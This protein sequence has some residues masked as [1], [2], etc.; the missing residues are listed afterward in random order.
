MTV[1]VVVNGQ[2]LSW[3]GRAPKIAAD[4]VEFVK[5]QFLLSEDWDGYTVTAQFT[6][7]GATYNQLLNN[8]CCALPTEIEAGRCFISVFGYIPDEAARGTVTPLCFDINPSGFVAKGKDSIPPT[9]DLYSQLLSKLYAAAG[10]VVPQIKNGTWWLWDFTANEY[11]DT[12]IIAVGGPGKDGITPHIGNNGNWWLRE[13]DTGVAA[14]GPAGNDYVLTED[15]KLEI[16]EQVSKHSGGNTDQLEPAE[17][18]I[19]KVFFGGAL[20]WTKDEVIMSFR[21]ISKTKDVRGWCKTKAQGNYSMQFAKKNQT[22]KLYADEDCTQKLKVGFKDWGEQNKFCFKANWVDPTHARNI[23]CANLW[24]ETVS[25]RSD[26]ETLPTEL[27]NSPRN[28]AVDGFPVKLYADEIYQGVYTLNIP[29]DDWMVGM[30][31]DNP[32][33]ILMCAETN[34]NGVYAETPCNFRAL[35]DGTDELHWSVEVGTNSDSVKTA[36]NNLIQFVM[37]NDGDAFRSGISN[38]L[39][40]QSAIDYYIHQY[41]INGTDGL[42]KNMLLATYNGTKWHCGA[43]DM[44]GVLYPPA[45]N[46]CPGGYGEQFSLLWERISTLY[47]EELSERYKELR[48]T[49]Y[50]FA[51]MCTKFENFV[52]RIGTELYEEDR[53]VFPDLPTGDNY[54]VKRI[55]EY[56]RERLIYCDSMMSRPSEPMYRLGNEITVDATTW[57]GMVETNIQLFDEPKSFTVICEATIGENAQA[58]LSN[59]WSCT[60]DYLTLDDP[61]N[62]WAGLGAVVDTNG[63]LRFGYVP[64]TWA[65][66]AFITEN[67]NGETITSKYSKHA[68]VVTDGVL[69]ALYQITERGG[70]IKSYDPISGQK[71]VQHDGRL[72]LGMKLYSYGGNHLFDGTIHMFEIWDYAMTAEE[73]AEK[74]V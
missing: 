32:G 70:S 21:Y 63:G 30:D 2:S 11:R 20:P 59:V 62:G 24:D 49:V 46:P 6:Q 18:D 68:M 41:V 72:M 57:T 55:R 47:A 29:K 38:Y 43:Y 66:A 8:G 28:G 31:E 58:L 22:V 16:A 45:N 53:E 33:H 51:N 25:S 48:Q 56:I 50:S 12:G 64:D 74:L 60:N 35:W 36:L 7:R 44:D 14:Q 37:D 1:K 42:A 54:D 26:Y 13:V 3:Q 19:P 27:R 15:D 65:N 9:P 17:D 61:P 73:V 67:I 71:Y 69:T 39:D 52:Y 23:V 34:T 40:V 4:S 10:H 5:F